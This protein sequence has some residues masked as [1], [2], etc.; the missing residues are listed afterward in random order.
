MSKI[1]IQNGRIFLARR[2]TLT[3]VICALLLLLE[4]GAVL[5][6]LLQHQGAKSGLVRRQSLQQR[7]EGHR[8]LAL[9]PLLKPQ[10]QPVHLLSEHLLF[11]L[12]HL[13]TH[14]QPFSHH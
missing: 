9:V 11:V 4:I 10:G 14:E 7:V 8:L 1:P 13:R 12:P 2:R 3:W 6:T 5:K